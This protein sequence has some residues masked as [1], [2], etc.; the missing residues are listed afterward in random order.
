MNKTRPRR[1]KS[2]TLRFNDSI[3]PL[4]RRLLYI[5]PGPCFSTIMNEFMIGSWYLLSDPPKFRKISCS[6]QRYLSISSS[7]SA[8]ASSGLPAFLA[9]NCT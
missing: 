8:A 3:G 4:E 5:P 2:F 9:L 1:F 7:S 6:Q